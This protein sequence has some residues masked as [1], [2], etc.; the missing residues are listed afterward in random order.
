[1][2]Y[3]NHQPQSFCGSPNN[4]NEHQEEKL[5]TNEMDIE[6]RKQHVKDWSK[7]KVKV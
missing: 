4:C 7:T 5:F 1:M 3:V 2:A 6:H